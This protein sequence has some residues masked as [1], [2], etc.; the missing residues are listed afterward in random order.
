MK[1]PARPR[2]AG[3]LHPVEQAQQPVCRVRDVMLAGLPVMQSP[4]GDVKKL[5]A[6]LQVKAQVAVHGPKPKRKL[7]AGFRVMTA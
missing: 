4:L 1:A 6:A 3:Q 5:R 7:G 2:V